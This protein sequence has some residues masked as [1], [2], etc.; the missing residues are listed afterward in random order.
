MLRTNPTSRR[1]AISVYRAEDLARSSRDIPCLFGLM[2][3]VRSGMLRPTV[4]MRANNAF[5]LLPY[6]LFEFSLLAEVVA[7]ELALPL[8]PLIHNVISMHVYEPD[9]EAATSLDR[10]VDKKSSG[11]ALPRMPCSPSPWR[12]SRIWWNSRPTSERMRKT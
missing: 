7:A 6:N 11:T 3:H 4:L 9:F 8:G 5:G 1:A 10:W 2:F 12:N